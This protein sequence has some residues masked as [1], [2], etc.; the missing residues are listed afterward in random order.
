MLDHSSSC[1]CQFEGQ[2]FHE[3]QSKC[4]HEEEHLQKL[5][6]LL[7]VLFCLLITQYLLWIGAIRSTQHKCV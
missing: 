6:S 2:I 1:K 4:I 5:V 3:E 7:F